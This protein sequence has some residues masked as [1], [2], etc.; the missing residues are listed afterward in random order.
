MEIEM[1]GHIGI[2]GIFIH[3]K[4]ADWKTGYLFSHSHWEIY[5]LHHHF[6]V[7]IWNTLVNASHD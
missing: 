4:D 3:G 6:G 1:L 2:L 7:G 5:A